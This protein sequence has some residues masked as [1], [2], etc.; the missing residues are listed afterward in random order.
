MA[1]EREAAPKNAEIDPRWQL[2]LD[3]YQQL[4]RYHNKSQDDQIAYVNLFLKGAALPTGLIGTGVL[5]MERDRNIDVSGLLGVASGAVFVFVLIGLSIYIS[6][7][8]ELANQ[9]RYICSIRRIE[10][11]A[12]G[13]GSRSS[14]VRKGLIPAG[15]PPEELGR[16]LKGFSIGNVA[17]WRAQTLALLNVFLLCVSIFLGLAAGGVYPR[18]S[19][20]PT[21]LPLYLAVFLLG[22]V[23]L[24]LL[25]GGVYRRYLAR[26]AT[27]SEPSS[28]ETAAEG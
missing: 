1:L 7:I 10:A 18:P 17:W 22:W 11:L 26:F 13:S 24:T 5:I 16:M 3:S 8:Q 15:I 6:Y 19:N 23:A 21:L 14:I 28:A 12:A 27:A 9:R 20:L 25:G 4:W 2:L